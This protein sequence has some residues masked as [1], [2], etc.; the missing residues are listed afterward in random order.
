VKAVALVISAAV[1][2]L[3]PASALANP[4]VEEYKPRF[5]SATGNEHASGGGPD[6]DATNLPV[7]IVGGL[8][9]D[10]NGKA[11]A[12]L[13]ASHALGA[14]EFQRADTSGSSSVLDAL[15]RSLLDPVIWLVGL[16]MVGIV[17]GT[18]RRA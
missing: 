5:P 7:A 3:I 17:I 9:K 8:V 2:W 18:R 10:P 13:G 1:L 11:L 14:P 6:L 4:A 15:L 12:T 16:A